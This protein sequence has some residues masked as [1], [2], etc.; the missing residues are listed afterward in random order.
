MSYAN[1]RAAVVARLQTVPGIGVVREYEKWTVD[2][3]MDDRY[4][5]DFARSGVLNAWWVDRVSVSDRV[6]PDRDGRRIRRHSLYV[7]GVYAFQADGSSG[8]VFQDL[9]DAIAEAFRAGDRT[10][11][12]ACHTHGEVDINQ[13]RIAG[14]QSQM[15]QAHVA[16]VTFTVEEVIEA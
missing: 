7:T 6:A 12:G 10:L 13:I 16:H 5:A 2:N 4:V 14:F 8:P 3:P 9:L 15:Q 11:G 1:I